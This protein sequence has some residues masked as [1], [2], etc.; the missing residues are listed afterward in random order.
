VNKRHFCCTIHCKSMWSGHVSVLI[1][2]QRPITQFFMSHKIANNKARP[3]PKAW[4]QGRAS[5]TQYIGHSDVG[6][7]L[8][9]A[10]VQILNG[11]L[12][13]EKSTDIIYRRSLYCVQTSKNT[14][15]QRRH[16]DDVIDPT[17]P[18]K[19]IKMISMHA[20][21]SQFFCCCS[22]ATIAIGTIYIVRSD[23]VKVWL[24]VW[25]WPETSDRWRHQYGVACPNFCW[26]EHS[27]D[28]VDK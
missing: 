8:W 2:A 4:S 16:I 12:Q 7:S 3:R 11:K 9:N 6:H 25:V 23:H 14:G 24:W 26:F 1:T 20:Y 15:T 27:I 10:V 18:V 28:F 5:R 13:E 17:F 19:R 22:P 21:G